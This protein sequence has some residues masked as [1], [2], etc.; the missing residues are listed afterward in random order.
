MSSVQQLM[1]VP[2]PDRQLAWLKESLQCA[3]VLEH[4]TLPPYLCALWS[5]V[6]PG[7]EAVNILM[8]IALEEMLHMSLA[9]NLLAAVGGSPRVSA[10]DVVP[11]Y[12]GP[13]PCDIRPLGNPNLKVGLSRLTPAVVT[14]VFMAIEFPEHGPVALAAPHRTFHTIGEFYA[15]IRDRF[16]ALHPP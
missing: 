15:A 5:I 11:K 4:S 16:R 2:V 7:H 9:C 1:S 8:G 6:D 3:I 13:L 12:P 10:P 14:D